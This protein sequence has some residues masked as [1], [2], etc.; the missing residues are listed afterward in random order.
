MATLKHNTGKISVAFRKLSLFLAS[1]FITQL[2][3]FAPAVT[4]LTLITADIQFNLHQFV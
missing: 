2:Q 4:I 1:N 3:R